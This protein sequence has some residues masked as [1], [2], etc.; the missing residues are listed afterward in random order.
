MAGAF[1]KTV[2]T[3]GAVIATAIGLSTALA[4]AAPQPVVQIAVYEREATAWA[5]WAW[6]EGQMPEALS[7]LTPQ[8][9]ERGRWHTLVAVPQD[10][11]AQAGCQALR[12]SGQECFVTQADLGAAT[13]ISPTAATRERTA[14][15]PVVTASPAPSPVS[16]T[17]ET[18][19]VGA[20]PASSD[21]AVTVPTAPDADASTDPVVGAVQ[22]AAFG[23]AADAN[24]GRDQLAQA[25]APVFAQHGGAALAVVPRGSLHLVVARADRP[26]R[27]CSLMR[28]AG[29]DCFA[30]DL[31]ET[32]VAAAEPAT[33]APSAVETQ[34][35]EAPA[36]E[37]PVAAAPPIA[38]P[39]AE[40]RAAETASLAEETATSTV[41]VADDPATSPVTVAEGASD[42]TAPGMQLA[43]YNSQAAAERGWRILSTRFTDL[44]DRAAPVYVETNGYIALKAVAASADARDGVCA[45]LRQRGAD[46]IAE[47]VTLT[48]AVA[49]PTAPPVETAAVPSTP[50]TET[51]GDARDEEPTAA[52]LVVADSPA[53]TLATP[54]T[55]PVAEAAPAVERITVNGTTITVPAGAA[56][57]VASQLGGAGYTARGD[58]AVEVAALPAPA[59]MTPRPD[60]PR[61]GVGGA[62]VAYG[63]SPLGPDSIVISVADR[64]LQYHAPDG[65][66]YVWPVAVGRHPSYSIL[67]DTEITRKRPNPTWVP[68]PSM[69]ERDPS[70][71]ASVGPGPS[72]PLGAYALNLG[73][74]YIRIHGT[75]DPSSV[76][77]AASSG[78]YRMH[79][80]AIEF[81]FNSVDVGT[82]VRVIDGPLGS[83][84]QMT[85]AE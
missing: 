7:G 33:S 74:P 60:A 37:T 30:I 61:F 26:E 8:V 24:R 58:D 79:A 70:L 15:T 4:G 25:L 56:D 57:H 16:A 82:R 39:T 73:F 11:D 1:S 69:R 64:K 13:P 34:S 14:S 66:V 2:R 43:L 45:T 42:A 65:T 6:L 3:A 85:A 19:N 71:P 12:R 59:P 35:V 75:N 29:R 81:L 84:I 76:G 51:A 50:A 83:P 40:T 27:L 46:C 22:V 23:S 32:A 18:G 21:V 53:G 72:N 28:Q 48:Q 41:T 52:P 9:I 62:T 17:E 10:G 68:T 44:R 31:P 5:G 55:A 36:I 67:G 20:V 78:C 80:D 63:G 77:E 38:T 47:T 54:E 49:V